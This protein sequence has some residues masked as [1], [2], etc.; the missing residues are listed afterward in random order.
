V[1]HR[2]EVAQLWGAVRPGQGLMELA[3]TARVGQ[4]RA[5]RQVEDALRLTGCFPRALALLETGRM[6]Q[7]TAEL[8][9]KV[10]QH[11]SADL[12]TR[13]G[14]RVSDEISGLDAVDARKVIVTAV[15]ELV[16]QEQARTAHEEA[17]A[18]RG[19]WVLLV[20]EGMARIGAETDQVS[21]RRWALDFEEL[22]RAQKVED[23]RT[24]RVRCT[25]QR[26]ADVFAELPSRHLALIQAMQQ[27][28]ASELRAQARSQGPALAA[29][30]TAGEP[31]SVGE[32]EDLASLLC[33]LPVRN[34][35]TMHVHVPVTTVLDLDHRCAYMEGL[36]VLPAF[37]AR[38]LRPV[39]SL[40]RLWVDERTGT[41]LGLDPDPDAPPPDGRTAEQARQR[42]LSML[43]PTA[44]RDDAEPA[45]DPSA[46]LRRLVQVRD[47]GCDGPGCAMPASA[48]ELDHQQPYAE[49]GPT[50]VWNLRARSPRCHHGKHQGWTVTRHPDGSSTWISPT[51]RS[52]H[53]RSPWRPIPAPEHDLPKPR[54]DT[55]GDVDPREDWH[56]PLWSA[57][58][59]P[60]S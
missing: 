59:P 46:R 54:P 13:V 34:P 35:R 2:A 5:A 44:L 24:G 25:Q 22:V 4:K 28:R 23:D 11:L 48:C 32:T 31:G 58:E 20:E 29:P 45:H 47:L 9:L 51:G 27:G 14:A 7:G 60:A 12:Q 43:R 39:A 49:Q 56:C 53:R 33:R 38:L 41:P 55:L 10:T 50:A 18:Q 1:R 40:A 30:A 17:R 16:D 52:Y 8:L 37:Q 6:R 36:G 26:R 3:G 21:A 57:D 42:L 15:A 19:V